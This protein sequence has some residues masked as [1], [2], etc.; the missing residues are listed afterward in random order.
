MKKL[1]HIF[2]SQR[3]TYIGQPYNEGYIVT[4]IGQILGETVNVDEI[5][6]RYKIG[7]NKSNIIPM[8]LNYEPILN[9][10]VWDTIIDE[11]KRYVYIGTEQGIPIT[12]FL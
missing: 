11:S 2:V 9:S 6:Q 3:V 7:F 8:T 4:P 5:I 12:Y 10:V 1:N